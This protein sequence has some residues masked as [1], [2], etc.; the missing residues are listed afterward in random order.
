MVQSII[1]KDSNSDDAV[2]I[3]ST[4]MRKQLAWGDI[5][6]YEFSS[7]LGDNPAVSNGSPLQISWNYDMKHTL[8]VDFY[9]FLRQNNNPRRRKKELI[10]KA[11][12]RD[13]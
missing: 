12:E 9:E 3:D 7:I 11:G 6:I 1:R 10:M 2:S 4:S 8:D 5:T 13:S